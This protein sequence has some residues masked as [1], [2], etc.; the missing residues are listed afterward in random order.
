M[1][2]KTTLS[3]PSLVDSRMS[4]S[5]LHEM[6]GW[7]VPVAVQ[8]MKNGSPSSGLPVV[9][10]IVMF[11]AAVDEMINSYKIKGMSFFR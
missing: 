9:V 7:G 1:S 4:P 11:G 2:V 5:F 3:T 10:N 6:V 8:R